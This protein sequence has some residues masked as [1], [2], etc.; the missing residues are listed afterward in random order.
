M[1]TIHFA[2]W[3]TVFLLSA[4]NNNQSSQKETVKKYPDLAAYT[5]KGNVSSTQD[6]TFVIDSMGKQKPDSLVYGLGEYKEGYLQAYTD[7]DSAGKKAYTTYEHYDNGLWKGAQSV[8]NGK[9]TYKL[10]IQL[11][12]AGHYTTAQSYDSTGKMDYYNTDIKMNEYGM[13]LSAKLYKADSSL[14]NSFT[15]TFDKTNYLGS[16][17]TD[18]TGKEK[19]RETIKVNDK[20]DPIEMTTITK[21]KDSS[22]TK[23]ITYNYTYDSTGNWTLKTE[24]NEKGKPIKIVK[25]KIVYSK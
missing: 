25:R 5:L 7:I 1:R 6:S 19:T 21:Q 20:G 11:D 13:L 17:T 22:I 23:V 9:T 16:V 2:L 14:V 12:T 10:N 15:N 18:S 3:A 24:I 8:T 4:C